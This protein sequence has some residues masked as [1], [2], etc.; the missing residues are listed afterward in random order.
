MANISYQNRKFPL[1]IKTVI[2]VI[3]AIIFIV[4]SIYVKSISFYIAPILLLTFLIIEKNNLEKIFKFFLKYLLILIIFMSPWWI[5]N[6]KKFNDTY[7][8]NAG[9]DV[10]KTVASSVSKVIRDKDIF[11]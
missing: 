1:K 2:I 9:D 10:L 5:H 6:F 4:L 7:G 3:T 11:I 8:H